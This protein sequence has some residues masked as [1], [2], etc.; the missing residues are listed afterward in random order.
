MLVLAGSVL[1]VFVLA[2]TGTATPESA[3]EAASLPPVVWELV[4]LPGIDGEP[5]EITEPERYTIQF[6]PDGKVA[7][8]ADC[9]RAGGGVTVGDGSVEFALLASTL[10]LC[11]PDS[12]AEPFMAQLTGTKDFSFDDEGALIL[13]GEQGAMR[14]RPS[15][16][17]VVW[18]W[19]EFQGMDDSTVTP[20]DPSHYTLEFL[21]EGRIAVRADCNRGFGTYATDGPMMTL[22]VIGLTKAMCPPDSLAD[23]FVEDVGMVSS[24]VFRDGTLYLALPVDAG[25]LAFEARYVAPEPATPAAG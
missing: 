19:H 11:P 13:E 25:I 1:L 21:P 22:E 5:V 8:Q 2:L 4:E 7:I 9:N 15:L 10:A 6:L 17:G 14:L 18:E 16:A 23:R 20:D 3:S 24:H 12:R